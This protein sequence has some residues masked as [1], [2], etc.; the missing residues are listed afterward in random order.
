MFST[1]NSASGCKFYIENFTEKKKDLKASL[2]QTS[3]VRVL[4]FQ[5]QG[6]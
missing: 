1:L 2:I 3:Y 4:Q 5:P 6:Q